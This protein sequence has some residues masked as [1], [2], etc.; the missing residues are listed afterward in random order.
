MLELRDPSVLGS[1]ARFEGRNPLFDRPA[2]ELLDPGI[3]RADPSLERGEPALERVPRRELLSRL[4]LGIGER[5]AGWPGRG[6]RT[7]RR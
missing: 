6:C 3:L 5:T 4:E 1:D 7:S 2:L